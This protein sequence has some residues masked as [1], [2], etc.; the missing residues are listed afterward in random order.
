MPLEA[1]SA[2]YPTTTEQSR[3]YCK[4]NPLSGFEV[5]IPRYRVSSCPIGKK[6][7]VRTEGTLHT[8][9]WVQ[10]SPRHLVKNP[11]R[12]PIL[13]ATFNSQTPSDRIR[14]RCQ[15]RG[16]LRSPQASVSSPDL[17][18]WFLFSPD[19]RFLA[20]QP[21]N[22]PQHHSTHTRH[23][24]GCHGHHRLSRVHQ[25]ITTCGT[26]QGVSTPVDSARRR[27]ADILNRLDLL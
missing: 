8:R 13:S 5:L 16:H 24:G 27:L 14:L 1:L 21:P 3:G 18:L 19:G 26:L 7:R 10:L 20:F 15:R 9:R 4:Q 6:L 17:S 22:T 12:L 23:L 25:L 2:T 11:R